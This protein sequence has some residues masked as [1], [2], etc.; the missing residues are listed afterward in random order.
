MPY[1]TTFVYA[2]VCVPDRQVFEGVQS[3]LGMGACPL[4]VGRDSVVACASQGTVHTH[5]ARNT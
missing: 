5:R 1:K 4:V 3:F 2:H